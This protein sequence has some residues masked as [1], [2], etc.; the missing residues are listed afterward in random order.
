MV[1]DISWTLV[2]VRRVIQVQKKV[3]DIQTNGEFIKIARE[4]L[5]QE[6]WDYLV[7]GGESETTLLRNRQSIDS[8]AF[9]PRVMRN[10]VNIDT[11]TE[12][13]GSKLR[14][15]VFLAPIGSVQRFTERG[16]ITTSSAAHDFG[17]PA[18]I[19]SVTKPDVREIR[20]VTDGDLFFQLYVRDDL[21]WILRFVDLASE[22]GCKGFCLTADTAN[23]G[24]RERDKIKGFEPRRARTN[25]KSDGFVYQA[26]LDW[27]VVDAIRKHS[28]IPLLVKGIVTAEDAIL[29][30]EHGVEVIYISNH[31]GRQLDHGRG[32]IDIIPEII[33]AVNGKAQVI[34]DGGFCRGTDIAKAIALGAHAVGIGKMYG[35]A[36]SAGGGEA[37][38]RM[39]EIL[40]EE[41]RLALALLGVTSPK[42]LCPEHLQAV[43]PVRLPS[44]SSAFPHFDIEK[45]NY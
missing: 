14:I 41:F 35:L 40:E 8:L 18:F 33:S 6:N 42:E 1:P 38:I 32:S 26:A 37:V 36:A 5:D 15:P 45:Y 20:E 16:G 19:S 44:F 3:S 4:N 28:S 17:I 34:V 13:L 30:V 12:L 39:L 27:D 10:V 11:S 23:Y 22:L 7:G 29:A 31:G 24:R 2:L 43:Q 9:R 21:D 25:T